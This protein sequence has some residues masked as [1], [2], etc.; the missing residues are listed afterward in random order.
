ML[1]THSR[2]DELIPYEHGRRLFEA[3]PEPKRFLEMRGGHNEGAIVT[4]ERYREA[5]EDFLET[6]LGDRSE[7]PGELGRP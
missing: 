1:V 4:G 6:A 5:F 2:E 3:A 7:R